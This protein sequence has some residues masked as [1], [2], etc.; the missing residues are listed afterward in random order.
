MIFEE[1]NKLELLGTPIHLGVSGAGW[2]G[3]GYVKAISHVKGMRV[4]LIAD[5]AIDLAKKAFIDT[6]I[7]IDQITEA[8]SVSTAMDALKAGKKVVTKYYDLAAQLDAINLVSDATP[9]PAS[10]AETAFSCIKYHKDVVMVN[11][12]ADVTVGRILKKKANKEGVLYTVSSGDEPGCLMELWDF[13][14]TLGYT[15]I[16][17]GKG[18]N[19]P[20]N[21]LATPETVAESAKKSNKDPYQVASYVDGTKTMFEMACAANATGCQPQKRSMIGPE[22]N[23]TTIS[24][25]FSLTEDGGLIDKPHTVDFVQGN[26]MSGGVFITVKVDD[27]RIQADLE[28]L[29]VGKGYYYTFFRPYH[30]WFLEAPISVARAFL[31]RQ[32]TLVPQD[33]AV[34]ES[35]ATAK[36][37]LQLGEKLDTF[38]GFTF[39]GQIEKAE[40][41]K[42][43]N[44]LPTGLAPDAVM[45]KPVKAGEIITWDDVKLDET[46]TVVK[47]RREQDMLDQKK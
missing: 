9:F 21:P 11:I 14:T 43:L 5:P 35:M 18:K 46:Q 16:V 47:L 22:A 39:Y 42:E 23:Q 24:H 36:R 1:L 8:N 33:T 37:D 30:L 38:G 4:D 29:K 19:N 25:L 41:A 44:S 31:Y 27:P 28:Y 32:T 34:A 17:M 15:P 6:G 7:A 13:V 10:G 26:A 2:L 20:L 45:T 3:T 12:E 40:I